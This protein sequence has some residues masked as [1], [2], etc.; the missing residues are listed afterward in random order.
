MKIVVGQKVINLEELFTISQYSK[1]LASSVEVVVDSQIFAD[2]GKIVGKDAA[3][4][5]D[6]PKMDAV[7]KSDARA[8]LSVKLVQILKLKS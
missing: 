7:S 6:Y 5:T 1:N 2:L 8:I 4:I 3:P